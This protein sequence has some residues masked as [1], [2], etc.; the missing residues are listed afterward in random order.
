M[1][2]YAM[3][4]YAMLCYAMLC[5]AMLCYAML[6]YAMLCIGCCELLCFVVIAAFIAA[7]YDPIHSYLHIYL[8]YSNISYLKSTL[9]SSPSLFFNSLLT[10]HFAGAIS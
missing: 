4:C 2:C 10:S 9:I 8:P 1:Q 3:L 7:S 5:Y 6:C